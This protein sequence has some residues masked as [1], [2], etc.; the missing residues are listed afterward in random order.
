MIEF[1]KAISLPAAYN[2]LIH[3][4]ERLLLQDLDENKK[5]VK[6]FRERTKNLRC[7]R[8]A[9]SKD[10]KHNMEEYI[11]VLKTVQTKPTFIVGP[12]KVKTYVLCVTI[13][14][15]SFLGG[16]NKLYFLVS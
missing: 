16:K 13:I 7:S 8:T 11:D 2:Q 1:Q 12:P 14:I 4:F 15:M 3:E 6:V 9:E 5:S 10:I